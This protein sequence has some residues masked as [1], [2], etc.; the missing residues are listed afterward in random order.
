MAER[1]AELAEMEEAQQNKEA[2]P[3]VPVVEDEKKEE[4]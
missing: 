1:E 4:N 3:E 2:T